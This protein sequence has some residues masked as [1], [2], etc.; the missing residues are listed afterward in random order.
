MD[1]GVVDE[2]VGIA[3][4]CARIGQLNVGVLHEVGHEDFARNLLIP[5]AEESLF[6]L[7]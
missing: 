7:K 4:Q 3:G 2:P 6:D 5:N 1:V